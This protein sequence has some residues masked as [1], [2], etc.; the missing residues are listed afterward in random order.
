MTWA[1]IEDGR[2]YFSKV[3]TERHF[4]GLDEGDDIIFPR[5]HLDSVADSAY[6]QTAIT[7]PSFPTEWLSGGFTGATKGNGARAHTFTDTPKAGAQTIPRQI[8]QTAATVVSGLTTAAASRRTPRITGVRET[9]IHAGIKTLMTAHLRQNPYIQLRKVL[10]HANMT[11]EDLPTLPEYIKNGTNGLCYNYVLGNCTSKYCNYKDGH[12]LASK[13][14]HEFA[15][16]MINKLEGP[17]AM[18]STPVAVAAQA[19]GSRE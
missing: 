9:D 10:T 2:R 16:N 4:A 13:I 1:V 15:R 18:F 3:M 8:N 7:R 6:T 19:A 11:L 17:L 12:A 5:S 14:T